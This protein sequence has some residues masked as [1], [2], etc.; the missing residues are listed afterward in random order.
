MT[1]RAFVD[2]SCNWPGCCA[3]IDTHFYKVTEARAW[4]ARQGWKLLPGGID[5]CGSPEQAET[6]SRQG[7][8]WGGHAGRTDHVP[9][10]KPSEK[11][12]VR[13]SCV[14]GWKHVAEYSW[15]PEG[16]APRHSIDLYWGRHVK[17]AEAEAATTK[18]ADPAG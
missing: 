14:C 3:A 17:Q 13:L 12:Y 4:A 2:I 10:V 16:A 5:V 15:Q 1:A 8:D 18:P 7:P 11:G 9:V 6:Y